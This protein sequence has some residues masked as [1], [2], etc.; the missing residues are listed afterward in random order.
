LS[1]NQGKTQLHEIGGSG[2]IAV[3]YLQDIQ[4]QSNLCSPEEKAKTLS[5]TTFSNETT[6]RIEEKETQK[7]TRKK[8]SSFRNGQ[9]VAAAECRLPECPHDAQQAQEIDQLAAVL[10]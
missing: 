3:L 8:S 1:I 4:T 9:S 10:H 5:I 2:G 6:I 7:F